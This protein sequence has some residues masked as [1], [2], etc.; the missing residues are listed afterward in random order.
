MSIMDISGGKRSSGNYSPPK[1]WLADKEGPVRSPRQTNLSEYCL[2]SGR[3]ETPVQLQ[4][5]AHLTRS[6][7]LGSPKAHLTRSKQMA[8]FVC[9]R[10]M[11]GDQKWVLHARTALRMC[12]DMPGARDGTP[13][14]AQKDLTVFLSYSI[15][16]TSVDHI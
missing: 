15:L 16:T 6:F 3:P 1:K 9:N 11:R 12:D 14:L 5:F 7:L 10:L 4:H 2:K 13:T 8:N